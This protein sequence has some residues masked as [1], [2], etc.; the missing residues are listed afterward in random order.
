[1]HRLIARLAPIILFAGITWAQTDLATIRGVVTDQS[2]AAVPTAKLTLANTGTNISRESESSE[3]G[4]FEIPYLVQG[5]YTLT[6]TAQ[7]FKNFIARDL[8][9][10]GRE[11]R[12]VDVK[13]ELGAVGSEITVS[14]GAAIIA[15]EGSQ[16]ASGFSREAF[17]NSPLS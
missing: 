8:L 11:M 4:D 1:M 9:I 13:L 17:V 2:G 5:T 14:G 15:T 7:G 16:V 12:R 3:N 6:V 10:R